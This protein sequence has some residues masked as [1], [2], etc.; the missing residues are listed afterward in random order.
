MAD[1]CGQ[2]STHALGSLGERIAEDYLE[3]NGYPVVDRNFR[4]PAG[5]ADL[6]A[7][8]GGEDV[9]VEVKLRRSEPGRGAWPEEAVDRRKRDRYRRIARAYLARNPS[10]E[11]VRFDVVAVRLCGSRA[12]VRH[13]KDAFGL[14]GAC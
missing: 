3:R 12:Y 11:S 6:V 2:E 9:L 7:V 8:D 5:E 4:C 10:V 1:G 13:I 14:D